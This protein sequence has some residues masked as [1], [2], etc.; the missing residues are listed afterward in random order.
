MTDFIEKT[1]VNT[2]H[3]ADRRFNAVNTDFFIW[4]SWNSDRGE[5][6]M[7]SKYRKIYGEC[8]WEMKKGERTDKWQNMDAMV[9]QAK[10]ALEYIIKLDADVKT[11]ITDL[12]D[13]LP[14]KIRDGLT[15][16][17]ISE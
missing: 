4:Y 7:I 16:V 14:A 11:A 9:A 3:N 1:K 5:R 6:V 17:S 13:K 12:T 8:V 15:G 2:V 10:E